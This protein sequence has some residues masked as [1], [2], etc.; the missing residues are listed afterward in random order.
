M[1]PIEGLDYIFD[2]YA[3]LKLEQDASKEEI[4]AAIK[5]RKSEN[6]PDRYVRAGTEARQTA[7]RIWNGSIK[8]E[9]VLLDEEK[10]GRFNERLNWFQE[11][12]PKLIINFPDIPVEM[13][14]VFVES[15]RMRVDIDALVKDEHVDHSQQR[16]ELEAF[17]GGADIDDIQL[18][19]FRELYNKDPS[20]ENV[21]LAYLAKVRDQFAMLEIEEDFAWEA[22]GVY[23]RFN[24][25]PMVIDPGD[26]A[27]N[28]AD[29]V[30]DVAEEMIVQTVEERA[31][32]LLAGIG[33]PILLLTDQSSGTGEPEI[34][35]V[36]T[37]DDEDKAKIVERARE[38]FEGRTHRIRE[39]AARKQ[40]VMKEFMDLLPTFELTETP[41]DTGKTDIFLMKAKKGE[42]AKVIAVFSIAE[43][44]SQ[45]MQVKSEHVGKS[46]ERLKSAE[47]QND[48]YAII[49]DTELKNYV[50]A[51]VVY[52]Y[53][54]YKG[55]ER[56]KGK[57]RG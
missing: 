35:A 20:N 10:R 41:K 38:I 8:C 24:N 13:A 54:K 46:I 48:S 4:A 34:K 51:V 18:G 14:A 27:E 6:H 9:E 15:A 25:A 57:E 5:T 30:R 45:I 39:I 7:A 28:V 21:K 53:K 37:L 44:T 22:A 31:V 36:T 17:T 12:H 33:T 49:N 43:D 29:E 50:A 47:M 56:E 32:A 42:E 19:I 26:Y 2:R 3:F 52:C 1:E 23:G 11:N 40:A 16:A 55:E